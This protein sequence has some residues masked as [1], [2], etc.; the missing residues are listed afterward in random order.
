MISE[1]VKLVGHAESVYQS[2]WWQ[3]ASTLQVQDSSK[4]ME[5]FSELK[6]FLS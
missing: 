3:L 2:I 6:I 1:F 4:N 5:L